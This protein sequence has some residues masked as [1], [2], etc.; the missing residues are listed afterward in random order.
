MGARRGEGVRVGRRGSSAI[1]SGCVVLYGTAAAPLP[2]EKFATPDY[3]RQKQEGG[4]TKDTFQWWQ[5]QEMEVAFPG[6]LPA[7]ILPSCGARLKG[8]GEN[9]RQSIPAVPPAAS[10]IHKQLPVPSEGTMSPL[11][12]LAPCP[13]STPLTRWLSSPRN[14]GKAFS[15]TADENGFTIQFY[16]CTTSVVLMEPLWMGAGWSQRTAVAAS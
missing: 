1:T 16:P 2:P 8:R 14:T 7:S 11:P 4:L 12:C 9:R 6:L 10:I 15:S 13:L 3:G 5:R